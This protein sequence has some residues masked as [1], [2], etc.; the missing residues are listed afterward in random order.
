MASSDFPHP[1]PKVPALYSKQAVIAAISLLGILLHLVLRFLFSVPEFFYELPLY[2]ALAA[3]GVPLVFQLTVKL[4]RFEF[5]SD[6]IAGMSIVSA[7]LLS[8]YLVAVI[9]VLMLSGGG[10][11]ELFA[12][13]RASFLLQALAKRMPSAAHKKEGEKVFDILADQI[14]I[15]DTLVIYPHEIC[16]VDGVVIAEHG[17]MDESYLTGEPVLVAKTPGSTVFSGAING[18]SLLVIRAAKKPSDSR[19]AKIMQVMLESQQHKPKIRR[20]GDILGAYYT[21]LALL[22]AA[23]AWLISG[24]SIRFLAVLVIATPCPLL[25]AIPVAIIGGISLSA[26]RGIIIKNAVVL[27]QISECRTMIFDKTGTLTYGRPVLTSVSCYG[28]FSRKE[29]LSLAATLEKYSKH[30]LSKPI[31]EAAGQEGIPLGQMVQIQEKPGEGLIGQIDH[32]RIVITGRAGLTKEEIDQLPEKTGLECVL[33]VEGRLAAHFCFHDTP[34]EDSKDFIAHLG[35]KHHF[36]RLLIVSGDREAEVNYLAEQIGIK[37]VFA[38]QTPE[39]KVEIVKKE[40]K[41][42]KVVYL[43]DGINDAPALAISTVG[44]AFGQNSD[45]V[46]ESADAVV[47]DNSLE[48]VDEFLHIS[49]RMRRIALQSAI[50]GIVLSLLGTIVAAFGYLPPL[51]GAIAQEV[52]DVAVI[53]NALRVAFPK[54]NLVDY[55]CKIK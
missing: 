49:Q 34:R 11:L 8:Q 12:I 23:L 30:P 19:Y 7:F 46:T 13:R 53:L 37:N 50:G 43:G 33:L 10:A 21:P 48:R 25:L 4:F 6:L 26:N 14:N 1:P 20:L 15:D 24:E 5:S 47:L 41:E 29:T 3:G 9:V 32:S 45:I 22:I 40:T 2:I 38:G 51:V 35:P 31:I 17:V 18:D 44:I 54:G 55:S 39:Q 16:P 27:E 52:I 42:N 36:R 28:K